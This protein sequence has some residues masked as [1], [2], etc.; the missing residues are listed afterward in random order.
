MTALLRQQWSKKIFEFRQYDVHAEHM[1]AFVQLTKAKIHL[2]TAH[3]P[4]LGYWNVEFGAL[5]SVCHMWIYDSLAHRASV[6][7][8]LASD[9]EWN[10]Q[11]MELVKPWWARQRNSVATLLNAVDDAALAVDASD[12]NHYLVE[13]GAAD[14]FEDGE[15][16]DGNRV[17]PVRKP[18]VQRLASWAVRAGHLDVDTVIT[19]SRLKSLD[20]TIAAPE[21]DSTMQR[22]IV[23]P[24]PFSRLK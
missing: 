19:L 9:A 20:A 14:P 10:K 15:D 6:R 8:A 2:R 16:E 24:L 7:A 13:L 11:Y 3:S 18:G 21:D 22:M 5:N 1:A 17:P 4:L 12:G 23:S